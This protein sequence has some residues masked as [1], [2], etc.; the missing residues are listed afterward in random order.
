MKKPLHVATS[1][2]TGTIYAGTLL[3]CN[4]VWSANKQ[5]VT[6]EALVAVA[7]H[8]LQFGKPVVI[9]ANSEPEFRITVERLSGK[10]KGK[11]TKADEP[12][13]WKENGDHGWKGS[14]G[15]EFY[16]EDGGPSDNGMKF[17]IRCGNACVEVGGESVED[18]HDDAM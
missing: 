18:G 14:C 13:E 17:C 5:D 7:E 12:C 8:A 6:V 16:L 10:E 2:L 1:P 15:V 3:K 11:P 4:R 9:H